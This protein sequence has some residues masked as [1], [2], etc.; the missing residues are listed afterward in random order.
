MVAGVIVLM[1]AA[2]FL[3]APKK[4]LVATLL[5]F[6]FQ[7]LAVS[8]AGGRASFVG[9]A[10]QT[11]DEGAIAGL[12]VGACGRAAI[13]G[14]PLRFRPWLKW[15]A[16]YMAAA[17]A[18]IA[19]QHG[20]WTLGIVGIFLIAK[21]F[22]YA[23]AVQQVDWELADIA[24]WRRALL[25]A[26]A[27][28]LAFS[29]PDILAPVPF[30]T[31]LGFEAVVDVRAG[32]PSV[33]S[34]V[35]HPGGYGYAM[36]AAALIA[37][38][39]L[40]AE[41]RRVWAWVALAFFA[42]AMLAFRR[43]TMLGLVVSAVLVAALMARRVD[44]RLLLATVTGIVV[45]LL[46]LGAIIIPLLAEGARGYISA[47]ALT[48]QARTALYAGSALLA[49]QHM[50]FGVGVGRYGSAGSVAQYSDVYYEMGFNLIYGMSPTYSEFIT[51]TFWPQVLGEAGVL[52]LVGYAGAIVSMLRASLVAA[53]EE[54]QPSELLA[55]RLFAPMIAVESLFESVASPTYGVAFP[56]A[57]SCGLL[58]LASSRWTHSPA[59]AFETP[60]THA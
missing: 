43:K 41:R 6:L 33:V 36:G 16:L 14:R 39:S 20:G 42:G 30:R 34:L 21:G 38:A 35:G 55:L 60:A 1:V 9:E 50:P 25:G 29:V 53:R 15:W 45:L 2:G 7:F 22:V 47:D 37:L 8:V 5:G 49:A 12:L 18:S 3:L 19:L 52:G 26:F 17:L 40:L 58:A 56:A 31:A 10:L 59:G 54:G 11:F 4:T 46:P 51:D 48:A 27:V 32:V 24:L 44:R 28:I 13:A 57:L 23:F